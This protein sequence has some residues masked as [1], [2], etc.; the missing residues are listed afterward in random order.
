M[1]TFFP[2]S[3]IVVAPFEVLVEYTV[4][5][6]SVVVL[7][8]ELLVVV[9]LLAQLLADQHMMSLLGEYVLRH[10]LVENYKVENFALDFYM[11]SIQLSQ[12]LFSNR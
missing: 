6:P 8:V 4:V 12:K 7:L 10:N 11:D 5:E 1:C 3:A 2:L 9:Q